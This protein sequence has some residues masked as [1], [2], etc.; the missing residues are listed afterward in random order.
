MEAKNPRDNAI[1]E[2]AADFIAAKAQALDEAALVWLLQGTVAAL[3]TQYPGKRAAGEMRRESS[4]GLHHFLLIHKA[5]FSPHCGRN[6]YASQA[7]VRPRRPPFPSSGCSIPGRCPNIGAQVRQPILMFQLVIA[8][9]FGMNIAF[10]SNQ[11]SNLGTK[12]A[13]KSN[14]STCSGS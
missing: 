6:S 13:Q 3:L 8:K 10:T 14:S 12:G 2:V 7:R 1:R 5:L 11:S 4:S 9:S